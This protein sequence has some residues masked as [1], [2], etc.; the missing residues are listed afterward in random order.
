MSK[1]SFI[2]KNDKVDLFM[3]WNH[4]IRIFS[5]KSH[6]CLYVYMVIYFVYVI[7]ICFRNLKQLIHHRFSFPLSLSSSFF[8]SPHYVCLSCSYLKGGSGQKTTSLLP[9]EEAS[10]ISQFSWIPYH[11]SLISICQWIVLFTILAPWEHTSLRISPINNLIPPFLKQE[12]YYSLF[13]HFSLSLSSIPAAISVGPTN[14]H[15]LSV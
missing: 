10:G 1:I 11:F 15:F 14:N 7:Y 9:N 8:S 4:G 13:L 12:Q 5:W 3:E 6:K 2:K